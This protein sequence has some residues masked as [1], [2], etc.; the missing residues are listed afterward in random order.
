[1]DGFKNLMATYPV[2]G[3]VRG[4]GLFIGVE[5]VIDPSTRHPATALARTLVSELRKQQILMSTD[6]VNDNVLKIKPPLV[7]NRQDV[8]RVLEAVDH[9]LKRLVTDVASAPC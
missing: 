2:I 7:F 8:D 5:F 4:M 9:T 3:D 6:G 1:M